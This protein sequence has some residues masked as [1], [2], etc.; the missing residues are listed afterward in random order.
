MTMK[1]RNVKN[2]SRTKMTRRKKTMNRRRLTPGG[3]VKTR[4]KVS[5]T[6]AARASPL[7]AHTIRGN[8]IRS[9]HMPSFRVCGNWYVPHV[10]FA[11]I[12][13]ALQHCTPW[14]LLWGSRGCDDAP[15]HFICAA[16][17]LNCVTT[18][19]PPWLVLPSAFSP[20]SLSNIKVYA[21]LC[22]VYLR[23]PSHSLHSLLLRCGRGG[24]GGSGRGACGSQPCL[25]CVCFFVSH[26]TPLTEI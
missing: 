20:T 4:V 13:Y 7:S 23:T 11:V 10:I 16:R 17:S 19:T 9:L 26:G 21:C 14:F 18:S 2:L 3:Q 25:V 8:V 15:I 12:F 5:R 24:H 6:A 22:A 1:R